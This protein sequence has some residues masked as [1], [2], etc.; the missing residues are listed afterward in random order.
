MLFAK[1]G[2]TANTFIGET[3]PTIKRLIKTYN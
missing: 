1:T 3:D 2:A